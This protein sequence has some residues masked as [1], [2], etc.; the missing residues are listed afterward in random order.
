MEYAEGELV[1]KYL[2]AEYRQRILLIDEGLPG[3]REVNLLLGR[4]FVNM[5]KEQPKTIK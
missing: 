5:V 3:K 2:F 1:S 4:F